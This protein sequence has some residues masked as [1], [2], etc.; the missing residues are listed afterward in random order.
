MRRL[1]QN[2]AA[3]LLRACS[4]LLLLGAM[5]GLPYSVHAQSWNSYG[6]DAQHDALA[7][8]AS[9]LPLVI[10]W[11][12]PV[13]LDP[14]YAGGGALYTHYGSPV[15]TPQNNILVPVKTGA[16]GGFQVNA[17]HAATGQQYAS[18]TTDYILPPHNW[19][20]PMGITL[21]ADGKYVAIPGAGG[22]V[23][24]RSTPNAA[25]GTSIRLAFF[26]I[27]NYNTNPQAF[28]NAIQIC[29]PITSDASDNLYFGYV[30]TGATVPGY[31][32]GILSGLAKVSLTGTSTFVS[33]QALAQDANI[34]EVTNNCAPA[35]TSDGSKLYVAVSQGSYS[36]G[37][38][39]LVNSD[40]LTPINQ[41]ALMDPRNA[42]WAASLPDD[43]TASPTIGPDGD[44]YFGVLEAS[45]PSN[46]AR[47]W[48]L[49]FNSTLTITK[50]PGAFGWDDSASIVP[51]NLVPSYR[52][53]SSYVV[54]TK[55]N[56]YAD[57]GIGGNGLN[58]VAVLDPN[59]TMADPITGATVMNEVMTVLGPTPNPDLPGVNEWCINSA[60]IDPV[61]RCAVVNSEDGHVY[62]W[63]FA[64]N[65]LSQGLKLAPPTGEAYTLTAIGPDGAVYAINNAVLF[66]C[67][68]SP[69]HAAPAG[70]SPSVAPGL[71]GNL[72][73][74]GI[75]AKASILTLIAL[76]VPL[77]IVAVARSARR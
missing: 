20:P 25:N 57:P 60:A 69:G 72:R 51:K 36:S 14:Q 18:W 42:Q 62:R 26:G 43:G 63:S 29:T 38:L 11:S 34:Q 73:R 56:N 70:N 1:D 48:L 66:C 49:H 45:F 16:D 68:I 6:R 53:P 59:V 52:G 23:W 8:G 13:D 55:Y 35:L 32:N 46:H 76:S 31:P 21:T 40:D 74:S 10:R 77:A 15:I 37:Y 24:L 47:G 9:Q 67:A 3:P 58:K 61:N 7:S 44:V 22:T 28:N 4:W 75:P 41:V 50:T 19:T 12:T 5:A 33:A 71:Q 39:C 17:F 30:S 65:T 27:G 2:P 64:T 54:L